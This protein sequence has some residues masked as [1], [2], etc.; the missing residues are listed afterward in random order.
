M[1][2]NILYLVIGVL[3]L[4]SCS[5]KT[6]LRIP[7]P[8][9]QYNEQGKICNQVNF[10]KK[11]TFATGIYSIDSAMRCYTYNADGTLSNSLYRSRFD[12]SFSSYIS[13]YYYC[14]DTSASL[15]TIFG[16]Y[17]EITSDRPLKTKIIVNK[18]G[19][20]LEQWHWKLTAN[21]DSSPAGIRLMNNYD[22]KD[23]SWNNKYQYLAKKFYYKYTTGGDL[24]TVFFINYYKNYPGTTRNIYLPGVNV[25]TDSLL[26]A[27]S[28]EYFG[29][30][31][32][33]AEFG[34]DYLSK[35][36]VWQLVIA[37]YLETLGWR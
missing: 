6:H 26:Y 17:H 33:D 12:N 1:K 14:Y 7:P 25:Y 37:P 34:S 30:E 8:K 5:K 36:E 35:Q 31:P 19:K 29:K 32:M 22:L 15:A 11:Y 3:V 9:N 21:P 4:L 13:K 20:I 24:D 10:H 16:I 28:A 2:P 27:Q 18:Q 23:T